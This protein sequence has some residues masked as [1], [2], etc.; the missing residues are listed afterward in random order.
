MY[1]CQEALRETFIRPPYTH[2]LMATGLKVVIGRV[3]QA[4]NDTEAAEPAPIWNS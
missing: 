4:F 2:V 1:P 3:H